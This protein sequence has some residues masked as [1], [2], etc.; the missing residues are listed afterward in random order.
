MTKP[1]MTERAAD[2]IASWAWEFLASP[3]GGPLRCEGT[4]F[5]A[6][7]RPIG[8]IDN[9]ILHFQMV[10]E[11]PSMEYYRTIG[12]AHFH[13]RSAVP[14]AMTSLDTPVYHDYLREFA[15]NNHDSLVVDVGGGDGRNAVPW[16]QDGFKRVV[17]IDATAAALSRFRARILAEN[18]EW[19]ERL[20]LIECDAR[21]LPL[22]DDT[23]DRVLAIES[24]YYLN[25]EYEQGLAECYRVMRP[26][27][28]LLLADRTYE[29][30]LLTRLLYYG[31]VDGM[32][33]TAER[34][35]M[36][37]GENQN[38]VRT[39]CFSREELHAVLTARGF[40]IIEW[41][42]ISAFSLLLSFLSKL[43]RLGPHAEA[44]LAA[45]HQLLISLGRTGCC[46]RCHVV[47]AAK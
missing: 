31:G 23:A 17:V 47:I 9:G 22:A 21:A 40:E 38:R 20:V 32:L 2:Q 30:A 33:E 15:P 41:G 26:Q 12:G 24:L 13:E 28:R 43:D 42:G 8:A 25:E 7:D 46:R 11:D 45:V 35:E 44:Q 39:R 34:R 5:W 36:W 27:A 14:F 19:L 1:S 37:D 18:P 10:S 3:G 16:L 4:T 29:G 6:A